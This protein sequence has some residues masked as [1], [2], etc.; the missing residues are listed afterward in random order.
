M[1]VAKSTGPAAAPGPAAPSAWSARRPVTIGVLVLVLLV[2]GFGGWAVFTELSGAI[3]AS[4]QIEVDQNRQVVQHLDG[5]V[6]D[7]ILVDEGDAVVTGDILIRLDGTVMASELSIIEDQ[8]YELIARIGRLEAERDMVDSIVFLPELLEVATGDPDVAKLVAGQQRL[9]EARRTSLASEVEQL[10]KRRGQIENQIEGI[11]AQQDALAIQIDL[12]REELGD[13]LKL[14]ANGLV[15]KSQVLSLQREE[16]R[17]SGSLGELKASEAE[18]AGR[19]TELEI[20]I[21]KLET[22]RQEDAITQLR[23]I[24][25]RENELSEQR[26]ALLERMERLDIR[27]PVSGIVYGLEVFAPRSVIRPADPVLYLIP[28]NRPLVIASQVEPIHIDQVYPGQEVMMRFSALDSR[29]TPELAGRVIKVSADAFS[30]EARGTSFYRAEVVLL[31]GEI[32]KLPEGVTLLPGMP[33]ETF[34]L[35]GDKS[36]MA[37]LLKPLADYFVKAFRES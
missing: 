35:T 36:P 28:Q 17:L 20:E 26:R 4:G 12:I 11:L 24:Q 15:P 13:K 32:D 27:A 14:M 10:S 7:E 21:L 22:S 18:G 23:D 29:T 2:G 16:A 3:V 1:I 9:F 33:V 25:Y 5:G 19:I 30:D 6:V 31:E 34:L 37:Y 8:L